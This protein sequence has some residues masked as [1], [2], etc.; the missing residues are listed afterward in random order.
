M[1]KIML[2]SENDVW[3]LVDENSNI[4][5]EDADLNELLLEYPEAK[6]INPDEELYV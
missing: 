6:L 4:L 5:D 1:T 3:V 2:D